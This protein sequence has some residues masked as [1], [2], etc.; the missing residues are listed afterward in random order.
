MAIN[1]ISTYLTFA[2]LQMA[3]EALLERFAYTTPIGLQA[4]LEFGNGRSSRFTA[5]QAE[6]FAAEWEVVDHK[7]NT[8]TGFSGTLFRFKGDTD[9]SRG[10]TK[11][12]LVV[13]L[14]STEFVDDAVRDNQA[15]DRLEISSGGWAIGQI[16]DMKTWFDSLNA[17][18]GKLQGKSFSITGYS[19]G[20]H[21][22]T[23]LNLLYPGLASRIQATYTFN[24]AGVGRVNSNTSLVSVVDRFNAMRGDASAMFTDP[25]A[26]SAYIQLRAKYAAS[27]VD[28]TPAA[29]DAITGDINALITNEEIM[30][31]AQRD[32][33][34]RAL[35][36]I[37]GIMQEAGRI[38]NF[39]SGVADQAALR[40]VTANVEAVN[41]DYQ[42]AVLVSQRDTR[43]INVL[44]LLGRAPGDFPIPS[45]LDIYGEAP[46]SSVANSQL[47][48]GRATPV[49]IEDQP[50]YRGTAP[51]DSVT[52]S[53]AYQGIKL[54]QDGFAV[55]DF[56][57]TH[58][59]VL[60]VDS[61]SIQSALATL[62]PDV[63]QGTLDGILRAASV[64]RKAASFGTQGS[65]E[66]D[67]LE[68]VLTGI[69]TMLGL[70]GD[71]SWRALKPNMEGGTWARIEDLAGYT[72]RDAFH[73]DL[74]LLQRSPVFR[75]L[76][77][78]VRVVAPSAGNTANARNEFASL[79]SLVGLS[80]VVLEA[81]AGQQAAVE[82]ALADAQ[83]SIYTAWL[84]DKDMSD[85][86]REAGKETYSKRWIEDRA[87][88]LQGLTLR[89]VQ[90]SVSGVVVDRS[91]ASSTNFV[92]VGQGLQFQIDNTTNTPVPA[93]RRNVKFGGSGADPLAGNDQNDGLYGGA[94]ADTLTGL[95]GAD[96]LEGNAGA[97][98]LDGGSGNDTLLGG[99][100][101]D[102][103][104]GSTGADTLL[105][106]AGSDTYFFN[107]AGWGDDV[108]ID[109]DGQGSLRVPGYEAGLPQGKRQPNG[110]CE[111][112]TQDVT[113]TVQQIT[114]T[115]K[116]LYIEFANRADTITVRNWSPGALGIT[117]DEGIAP[118]VPNYVDTGDAQ[119][120][121]LTAFHDPDGAG[122]LEGEY[123]RDVSL[124][125]GQGDDTVL[126]YIGNDILQGGAGSDIV[127]G[128]ASVIVVTSP[129]AGEPGDD[130]I[131]GDGEVDIDSAIA[132]GNVQTPSGVKGDWLG[133]E[134]GD[135]AIVGSAGHDVLMGGR[136]SDLLVGGAGDDDLNGDDDYAPGSGAPW[137]VG[138][139]PGNEFD[140]T[141]NPVVSYNRADDRG[142]G[143]ILYGG[144]GN[145]HL[146]G[147]VG[148]DML[149]GEIG[150]D[151][152]A[153]GDDD[154][155]VFGGDGDDRLSGD[156]GQ[157]T[158]GSGRPIV[159]GHDFIDGGAG[160][161][162][163]QGEGDDD[164]LYGGAGD[165]QLW[166]D[167][168]TYT[169]ASLK[170]NDWLEGEEGNDDLVGQGGADTLYGGTGN[171]SLYGDADDV[172]EV[173]Q[174]A[175]L[176]DGGSGSDY[177]RG[178]GGN[179]SLSGGAET[180]QL[181]GDAGDDW[182]AGGD[183]T[184]LLN[185]GEGH[186]VLMGNEGD[187]QLQGGIGNDV[188]DGGAGADY[189]D[190]GAGDDTYRIAAGE[191]S[192]GLY[193]DTIYD[194]SGADTLLLDGVSLS[195]LQVALKAGGYVELFWGAQQSV[196]LDQ[197]L[198]TSVR[199]VVAGNESTTL[200]KL[201]NERLTTQITAQS[202]R[203]G[204][205][206]LGGA[207]NDTIV[208]NHAGN[209]VAAGRGTDVIDLRSTAGAV[210]VASVGQG[211]DR[212]SRCGATAWLRP[213]RRTC[214]SWKPASMARRCASTGPAATH[215]CWR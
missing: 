36:R 206:V 26:Q 147:M 181:F 178:Y 100:G 213:G 8:G 112:P 20:G 165:D 6:Q 194:T 184:D 42:L 83:R 202:A 127:L 66:G 191:T 183:A 57:D 30:D 155:F 55:N 166:G 27:I 131:F 80:P 56:G 108:I 44:S 54:L 193:R 109:S 11:G 88:L 210:V 171:D 24:G 47:H 93:M 209:R 78:K 43:A 215:S 17:D 149:Y 4:A 197:G 12:Q 73:A 72:G 150:N 114:P 200:Q 59:L 76:S 31:S 208:V 185:A 142:A 52:E 105:G 116:D 74:D 22:A 61:L 199:T 81:K 204:G 125:G 107:T 87:A 71:A 164:L 130:R 156:Y 97:D 211:M 64:A 48:Y 177:L 46:P 153:G 189:L 60:L 119:P 68:N 196:L 21:L 69:A 152:A 198:T 212:C 163:A 145:D 32:F 129:P 175:D 96:H 137:S 169:D 207:G 1:P 111:T 118:L 2:N 41:L 84:A 33:L 7:A 63:T 94:G 135:D 172:L 110:K 128:E 3:A 98:T 49:F 144:A 138:A 77:G 143:D 104:E 9:L 159:Q 158:D 195:D 167:A 121:R 90:N 113:Y 146:L 182:L 170:G 86:D 39:Q 70:D 19:L 157:S 151:T 25:G 45:L 29:I 23:A 123:V 126:G 15:T 58:S 179:D 28:S 5:K 120:N 79:L 37:K 162:F 124:A 18:A 102:F 67:V 40:P 132:Q 203:D 85:A 65:A 133:G 91:Q 92:D 62:D 192:N 99:T 134:D 75:N 140:R 205:T 117:L 201:V 168:K 160:N 180:D 176:L 190:G 10:L 154:D 106:G 139:A 174:G 34:Y 136:G 173:N 16:A 187:D 148:D 186:D 141:Y 82:S 13:S 14:R 188:L 103:L 122:P 53:L 89:N 51:W 101:D 161:D 115:R 38:A 214:S 35:S 50:L 95:G